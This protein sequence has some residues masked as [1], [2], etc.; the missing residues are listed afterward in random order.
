MALFPLT[1]WLPGLDRGDGP[2]SRANELMDLEWREAEMLWQARQKVLPLPDLISREALDE[3][4]YDEDKKLKPAEWLRINEAERQ[5]ALVLTESQLA[6][7]YSLLQNVAKRRALPSLTTYPDPATFAARTLDERRD[8]YSAILYELQAGFI[9]GRFVRRLRREVAETLWRYGLLVVT[10]SIVVP[11]V[12]LYVTWLGLPN[13]VLPSKPPSPIYVDETIFVLAAVASTGALGAFFSRAMRFQTDL[14][15]LSFDVVTQTYVGQMLRLRLLYGVIGAV[16]FYFFIR[17]AF[18]GG[19]L[20]PKLEPGMVSEQTTWMLHAFVESAAAVKKLDV[21]AATAL[22]PSGEFAKL[23]VWSFLAGFSE[24]L[25]PDTI[26]QLEKKA[27][28]A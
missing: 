11:L 20:F 1:Q 7:Q 6:T 4:F 19:N 5:L 26:S 14:P 15:S 16:V 27:N 18:V 22:S 17:G 12:W 23:L 10:F 3:I 8:S 24:R 28:D 13:D 21:A 25:V 2:P 9:E